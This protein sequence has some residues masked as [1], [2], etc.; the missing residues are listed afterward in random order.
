MNKQMPDKSTII[1]DEILRHVP[2]EGWTS[3]A[4]NMAMAAL[5]L[6]RGMEHIYAPGG[7]LGL[8]Q[9]WSSRLDQQLTAEIE[10]SR[11]EDMRIRDKVTQAVWLRLN[12]LAGHEEAA[13]RGMS[14]LALPD[15]ASQAASQLWASSDAIWTALGD[16]SEDYNYYTKRGILSGVIGSTLLVWLGDNT[17]DKSDAR[18]FLDSRIKNVMQFEKLKGK[19]LGTLRGLPNPEEFLNLFKKDMPHRRR[20]RYRR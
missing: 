11:F 15:G 18:Q 5:D 2:F 12:L 4:V 3:R 19:T 9:L 20:R 16:Q 8:L 14:R 6:P 13:R 17:D 10:Q 7:A 1:L